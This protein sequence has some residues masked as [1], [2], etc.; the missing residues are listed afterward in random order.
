MRRLHP[1]WWKDSWVANLLRSLAV[2]KQARLSLGIWIL[3]LFVLMAGG[4]LGVL[5]F[6]R[7]QAV[8]HQEALEVLNAIA[9]LKTAQITDW[10]NER[11]SDANMFSHL[12]LVVRDLQAIQT[13]PTLRAV[14][15]E[16][17]TILSI[18]KDAN[19][20]RAVALFDGQFRCCGEVSSAERHADCSRMAEYAVRHR[21]TL[22]GVLQT[23][24]SAVEDLQRD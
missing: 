22:L 8:K 24:A 15:P 19:Y 9:D 17:L 21:A 13:T 16:V 11:K 5:A 7:D 10:R 3:L 4:I 14:S 20:Y 2:E 6:R 12:P 18:L 1:S 23:G